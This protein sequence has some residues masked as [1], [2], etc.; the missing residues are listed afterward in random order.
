MIG[1]T[2]EFRNQNTLNLRSLTSENKRDVADVP[3]AILTAIQ[4]QF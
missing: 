2:T 3:D 4:W 1:V